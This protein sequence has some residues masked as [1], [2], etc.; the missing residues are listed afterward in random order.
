MKSKMNRIRNDIA[1]LWQFSLD[2]FRGKYAGSL[3]GA[4]WAILQPLSTIILYWFVFQIGFRSQPVTN[5]PFILW[6]VSGLLPWLFFSDAIANATPALADYAY[7]VKKIKFNLHILPLV[8]ITS[9]MLV[10]LLLMFFV[11]VMFAVYGILPDFYYLQILFYL[12]Y[13]LVVLTGICYLTAT[14]F[15]FFKDVIQVVSILLQIGF[16][17]T[18]IV[19]SIDIMDEGIQ[20]LIR[21]TP[22]YYMVNGYRDA[23]VN[24]VWFW[25]YGISNAYY[26]GIAAAIL[27]I[28]L[29]VF[30]KCREHFADVL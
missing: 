7:L 17:T 23:F 1:F 15:V 3:V 29:I 10:H 26:W 5:V 4:S 30:A 21:C 8:K 2:D 25:N 19:W 27:L 24:K 6:L 9:G 28:G 22:F 13:M 12:V 20:N 16:W 11:I 14:L 18:P